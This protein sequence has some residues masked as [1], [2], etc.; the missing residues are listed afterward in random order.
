MKLDVKKISNSYNKS[1][2]VDLEM[3]YKTMWMFFLKRNIPSFY[4]YLYGNTL[5]NMVTSSHKDFM[6]KATV[7]QY[8]RLID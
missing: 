2:D 8:E 5:E 4:E 6:Y 3:D 7:V 1:E